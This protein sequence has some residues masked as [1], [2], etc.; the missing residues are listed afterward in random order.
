M[1]NCNLCDDQTC[2]NLNETYDCNN[3]TD[4]ENV[5]KTCLIKEKAKL[6]VA[7]N[8][9]IYQ[10]SI[11]NESIV[12]NNQT[13]KQ[14]VLLSNVLSLRSLEYN[15]KDNYI[16]WTDD[17]GKMLVAPYQ[18]DKENILKINESKVII[19][20]KFA[21][22]FYLAVDWIH[23]LIYWTDAQNNTIHVFNINNFNLHYV[24]PAQTIGV[25][26]RIVV[27][28]IESFIVWSEWNSLHYE[29]S[30]VKS[31]QNGK[32]RILLTKYQDHGL[33][34]SPIALTIDYSL[35]NILWINNI[36]KT[37]YSIDYNGNNKKQLFQSEYISMPYSLDVYQNYV[38]WLEL[39][40]IIAMNKYGINH[41]K[42]KTVF[43]KIKNVI[44]NGMKIIHSELQPQETNFCLH[45]TCNQD[46]ICLPS[47]HNYSCVCG[48]KDFTKNCVFK[49]ENVEKITS[50]IKSTTTI[51]L[52][53]DFLDFFTTKII[54]QTTIQNSQV[55]D[56]QPIQTDKVMIDRSEVLTVIK[57]EKEIFN[58]TNTMKVIDHS[59]SS[60]SLSSS[61]SSSPS[62]LNLNNSIHT[63]NNTSNFVDYLTKLTISRVW[64]SKVILSNV[65][66][67]F[68]FVFIGLAS[69]I[70]IMFMILLFAMSMR[71]N[72]YVSFYF[73]E[74][75]QV[76]FI[77]F[78]HYFSF[79][80]FIAFLFYFFHC[81]IVNFFL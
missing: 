9:K 13:L 19:S 2:I 78:F 20:S 60:S 66:A 76:C 1:I 30:I 33:H 41:S 59:T 34:F 47:N 48:S 37:L 39:D 32:N 28:P 50:T 36:E 5:N 53:N 68:K 40:E 45:N 55:I 77:L 49:N 25:L 23:N 63:I 10:L 80:F 62:S 43:I 17:Y 29:Y 14:N 11:G 24:L 21:D 22:P 81:L 16:I 38:Y 8:N 27:N 74:K 58:V 71:R 72:R 7:L 44:I 46:Y 35:K 79:Y 42:Y 70:L 56:I 12:I 26:S 75:K 18:K 67:I 54:E 64:I 52:D 61:P 73:F 4:F 15:I 65:K 3:Y 69:I 6:L 31:S 51:S 57:S